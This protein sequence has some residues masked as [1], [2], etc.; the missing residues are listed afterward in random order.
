MSRYYDCD[1]EDEDFPNQWAFYQKNAQAALK[2]KRGRKV[3]A[4]LREAL[5]ALPEQRLISSALCTVDH[6]RRGRA[7]VHRL[8][9]GAVVDWGRRELD[10]LVTEEGEG[11]CAVGALLW[12]RKVKAGVESVAAF[13]QLP[14]LM[15]DDGGIE[16]TAQRAADEAH[17]VYSLAWQLAYKNDETFED[18]TPEQRHAAFIAWIDGELAS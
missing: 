4:E 2:G 14:T 5:Q 9:N 10:E 17:V 7:Y 6:E 3:L 16:A 1:Y 8:D 11:V 12:W 15:A 13:E 18:M